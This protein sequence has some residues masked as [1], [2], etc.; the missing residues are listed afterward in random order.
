MNET[1]GLILGLSVAIA[2]LST[3][4]RLINV[5][6]PIVLV[7]GGLGIGLI[8]GLPDVTL[9]PDLVLVI[10]LPPL[11]YAAAFFASLRDLRRNLRPIS[12]NAIGLVIATAVGVAL[13]AHAL[14][15][16]M[17]WGAAFALGAIVAPTD[18]IAATAI[19][20]R[21]GA[22]RQIVTVIE[23]ESLINDGTALVLYRSAVA[24][25]VGGSF[26]LLEGS[27]DFVLAAA[28]GI[29][30]GLVVGT[31]IT[32]V[33]RRIEDP[34][35]EITIS[36]ATGYAAYLPAEAIDFSGVL[37][38]VTAG[39]YLG[40]KAP[41]IASVTQRL[42]GRPVWEL[43]QFLLNAILFVLIGLQLP[44]VVGELDTISAATLAGYAAAICAAVVGV[45]LVWLNTMPYLVRALDR[46]PEQRARRADWRV[47]LIA[48]WAGM[49]GAVSLAAALALP[50]QTDAGAAFPQRDLIIFLAFSVILFTLVAQGLTLPWLLRRLKVCDDG[51][52]EEVEE[53]HARL[54]AA[55]VALE[56][57][58]ELAAEDWTR[59]E[60]VERVRRTY[61]Y[62]RRR[63]SARRDGDDS[64]GI[65]DRSLAYQ[66]LV[67][68]LGEAQ[69]R[70]VVEL[71][72]TGE[73][74]HDVMLRIEREL[75]LEDSRLEI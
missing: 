70:A 36:L 52:E 75:D 25:V 10:F 54:H 47:R 23:G 18:P 51:R 66:R 33:R 40:W 71:R 13:V 3:I 7:I 42:Q 24:A 69:R 72:N 26:S 28:G 15:D 32:E 46:R 61:E 38:A 57:L 67:R 68:E 62:R 22:P 60:T 45:R 19:T 20:R 12:I 27:A 55:A 9:D 30:V 35:V 48:T 37:A 49:R 39:I 65:E 8:P 43:L 11:L 74:S 21:L 64:D 31:A 34:P 5:P 63:F 41:E 6:Y 50:L 29:A 2:A 16:G 14:I 1:G 4:A 17:T 58:D 56:R 59:P 53:L 73:I 44:I